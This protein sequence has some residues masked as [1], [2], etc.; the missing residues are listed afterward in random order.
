MV[1]EVSFSHCVRPLCEKMD[2]P[3]GCEKEHPTFVGRSPHVRPLKHR[4]LRSE[5]SL[6]PSAM[7][8]PA[9]AAH[10]SSIYTTTQESGKKTCRTIGSIGILQR[11]PSKQLSPFVAQVP[12]PCWSIKAKSSLSVK[13]CGGSVKCCRSETS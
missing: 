6:P 1:Q 5:H 10:I 9:R 7:R 3:P 12:M 11:N 2:K 8:A 4:C 13:C